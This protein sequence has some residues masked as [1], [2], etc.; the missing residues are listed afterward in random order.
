M[1][2]Y[3]RAALYVVMAVLCLLGLTLLPNMFFGDGIN[4]YAALDFVSI[5][6][7]IVVVLLCIP[8]S[9]I[10]MRVTD[11]LRTAKKK[12]PDLITKP[13]I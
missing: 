10:L 7:V 6:Y 3:C 13:R 1:T 2:S 4:G 5:L 11:R 9:G 8:L 12:E